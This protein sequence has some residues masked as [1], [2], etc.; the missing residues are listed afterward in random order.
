MF[1]LKC[2]FMQLFS[3]AVMAMRERL[4]NPTGTFPAVSS[5]EFSSLA[6][7]MTL[8]TSKGPMKYGGA[9]R[10]SSGYHYL[11]DFHYYGP[12]WLGSGI[13]CYPQT[14]VLLRVLQATPSHCQGSVFLPE[15]KRAKCH[16][17]YR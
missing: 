15:N 16:A 3:M 7:L 14:L 8:P 5:K 2:T 4:E 12:I 9:G 11:C 10:W 13:G 6:G 1:E 17:A